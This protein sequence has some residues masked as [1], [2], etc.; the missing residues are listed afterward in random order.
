VL[1]TIV[2]ATTSTILLTSILGN[3]LSTQRVPI[4]TAIS[5]STTTKLDKGK[6]ILKIQITA[7]Y[8]FIIIVIL[9]FY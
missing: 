5:N 3:L 6:L 8:L 2:L 7:L 4:Q 1:S 9:C